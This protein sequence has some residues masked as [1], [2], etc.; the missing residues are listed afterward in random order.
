ML[1][2]VVQA[3]TT[4]IESFNPGFGRSAWMWRGSTT[5]RLLS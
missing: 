1:S 5:W 4:F 2:N 3:Q